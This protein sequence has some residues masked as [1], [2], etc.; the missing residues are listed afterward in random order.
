MKRSS[1]LV[2]VA[3]I[4][5]IRPIPAGADDLAA[6]EQAAI[7]KLQKLGVPAFLWTQDDMKPGKPVVHRRLRTHWTLALAWATWPAVELLKL[8][9]KQ[10]GQPVQVEMDA[11]K[12]LT[13]ADDSLLSVSSPKGITKRHLLRSWLLPRTEGSPAREWER[14]SG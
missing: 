3:L 13:L 5:F 6:Q 1:C 11:L 12:E 2:L 10:L 8:L 14:R 7:A 4:L 9:E